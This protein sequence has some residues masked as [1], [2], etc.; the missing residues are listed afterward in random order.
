MLGILEQA[1]HND[2]A[3]NYLKG[4]RR[5]YADHSFDDVITVVK[6]IAEQKQAVN[7]L[8]FLITYDRSCYDLNKVQEAI[9]V[10]SVRW[11][12]V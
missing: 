10:G 11:S 8:D 12:D 4:L 6:R 2:A 7:A 5:F 1:P 3:W 9:A